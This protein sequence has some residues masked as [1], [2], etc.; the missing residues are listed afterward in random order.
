M[1][2]FPCFSSIFQLQETFLGFKM[3]KSRGGEEKLRQKKAEIRKKKKLGN[4][5]NPHKFVGGFLGH[6]YYKTGEK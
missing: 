3:S 1:V 4:M 5:K 6:F 2:Q